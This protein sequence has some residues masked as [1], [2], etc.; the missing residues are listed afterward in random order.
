MCDVCFEG[1]LSMYIKIFLNN[2]IFD[3]YAVVYK[4]SKEEQKITKLEGDLSS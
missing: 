2:T 4:I 1:C 3:K